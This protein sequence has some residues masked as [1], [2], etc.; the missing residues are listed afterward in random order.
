M[1]FSARR[2]GKYVPTLDELDALLAAHGMNCQHC[3]AKMNWT[4][5]EGWRTVVSLQHDRDGS[6]RLLCLA[7]NTSHSTQPGDS[8]Y[9]IPAD[10]KKC[11]GC[12]KIMLRSKYPSRR[13]RGF[14]M[15]RSMCRDCYNRDQQKL[16]LR[17]KVLA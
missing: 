7:C 13:V 8:F 2:K 6:I 17:R 1:R 16:K 14:V 9:E 15:Y 4:A 3:K 11:S 12:S 10:H 5:R